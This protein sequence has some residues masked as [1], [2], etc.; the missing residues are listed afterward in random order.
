MDNGA[1]IRF[2]FFD[3]SVLRR[4]AKARR[5]A[6]AASSTVPARGLRT[7]CATLL[8]GPHNHHLIAD[9]QDSESTSR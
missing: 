4:V 2:V 3:N 1:L 6:G 8:S 9:I 5:A 7:Q